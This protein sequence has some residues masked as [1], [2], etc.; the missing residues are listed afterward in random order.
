MRTWRTPSWAHLL[1]HSLLRPV[2]ALCRCWAS[3]LEAK[4]P[5]AP[6]SRPPQMT[7]PCPHGPPGPQVTGWPHWGLWGLQLR[8]PPPAWTVPAGPRAAA[9][10]APWRPTRGSPWSH[11]GLCSESSV[12]SSDQSPTGPRLQAPPAPVHR[13]GW[14]SGVC[15]FHL[16][17]QVADRRALHVRGLETFVNRKL[18]GQSGLFSA[19]MNVTLGEAA[20]TPG[21]KAV[22]GPATRTAANTDMGTLASLGS[23]RPGVSWRRGKH[24]P[25]TAERPAHVAGHHRHR[26]P[27][28]PHF[29]GSNFYTGHNAR[30]FRAQSDEPVTTYPVTTTTFKT[31]LQKVPSGPTPTGS[32]CGFQTLFISFASSWT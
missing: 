18:A 21:P 26:W 15:S 24:P 20:P 9:G 31:R 5:Q 23:W 6:A 25:Y 8:L 13:G 16:L 22:L 30:M 32:P 2:G 19:S 3:L 10:D 17:N 11:R 27:H 29:S 1:L 4:Q 14:P 28:L 12:C 7:G